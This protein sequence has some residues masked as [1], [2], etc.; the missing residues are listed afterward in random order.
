MN[1]IPGAGGGQFE[2]GIREVVLRATATAP[3]VQRILFNVALQERLVN[4]T[5]WYV[6]RSA[7]VARPSRV[8][9]GTCDPEVEVKMQRVSAR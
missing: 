2:G 3:L 5:S 4:T 8:L 7:V 1:W 6:F 9:L